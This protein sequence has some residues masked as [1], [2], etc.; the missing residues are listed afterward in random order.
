MFV[1][2]SLSLLPVNATPQVSTATVNGTI[3][4]ESKAV[5]PGVTVTATDLQTGRQYVA[6][7]DDRG[8]YRLV[9]MPPGTYKMQAELP[10]FSTVEMQRVELLVGQNATLGFVMKIAT[11]AETLTV[12]SEAP[13]VDVR[14][15]QVA[16][17]V[18]RRQMDAVPVQGRNWMELSM[19]VKGITTNNATT[20][21]GTHGDAFQL[22]LDGQQIKQNAIGAGSGQ[23]RFSREAIAEFQIVTNLFDVTQGRSTGVQVHAISRSG[24][25]DISGVLYG[26]FRD[27][28]L[29]AAD[30]VANQVLPYSNQQIG[31]VIGGPIVRDK[32]HYFFSYE[33][34][35]QPFTVFTQPAFLGGGSFTQETKTRHHSYLGRVDWQPSPRNSM[36]FR[37]SGFD[38]ESPFQLSGGSYP[39]RAEARENY[40]TNLVA[41]WN[42]VVSDRRVR[43]L[44]VGYF[45]LIMSSYPQPGFEAVPDYVFPGAAMGAPY[46]LPWD[47]GVRNSYQFRYDETINRERHNFKFGGEY[48][49]EIHEGLFELEKRGRMYFTSLPS[50][51]EMSRR[52]P[53]DQWNNP[54]AWDL[55][56]LDPIVQRYDI[57]FDPGSDSIDPWWYSVPRPTVALWF[58]D[59][60]QVTDRLTLNYGVRW[61]DDWGA[62]SPPEITESVIPIDN[63]IESG[64]FGYRAGIHDHTN[65]APRAGFVYNFGG[66]NDFVIRGGSGRYFSTPV[67]NLVYSHQLYNRFV[68]ASFANDRQP[69]FVTDPM[70]GITEQDV[71]SGS[72][73]VPAQ[74][75]RILSP[76]LKMPYTWQS[77]IGFQ[78]Q[79]GPLMAI[80]SDLTHW[81]W[82]NQTVARDPNLLFDPVTGYNVDPRFGRPNPAYGQIS[83]YESIGKQDYLALATGF[84]RRLQDNFQAGA[85][86]TLMFYQHDDGGS[87]NNMGD[88]PFDREA[89]W[90]RSTSF[91]RNTVRLWGMYQFP[92]GLS[93]SSVYF[94]GSGNYY[95]GTI[96]GAPYGKPGT[97]R[98][99]IGAPITIPEGMRE[100]F[101]GPDLIGS[102][103]VA[104]RN[105]LRGTP[106]HKVDLRVQQEIRMVG[107]VRLQLVGEVFNLFNSKNYGSFVT[108][109]NNS[110]F[111]EPN[112]NLGNAYVP[113]SGQ[114]G[115]RVSF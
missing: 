102:G 92:I 108:Q 6:V 10:S 2:L 16:G 82:Y 5:L 78:K 109:I 94:Y 12:I 36:S 1:T 63:G 107:N 28:K 61:D 83:W 31:G 79:L 75:K 23:P 87:W 25:N 27:D 21:P 11:L 57:S 60:W 32:L 15:S 9:N 38:T 48:L 68:S 41:T 20:S 44:H 73:A 72:V 67:T 46:N 115:F 113:R 53:I 34:E 45:Q 29:N 104:P 97:N 26:Y 90:A 42:S 13:L 85:T 49:H 59:T 106:L 84:T 51:A 74:T 58:G 96:S 110:R 55:T 70:R 81:I 69:G 17:Y 14:S 88:N 18:D 54:A 112:Q 3:T 35:N 56:G 89:E 76:D 50:P 101:D 30:P 39:T 4:D 8:E 64:D 95:G 7:S 71:L 86:Y 114:L 99:N 52:F 43:V 80:E 103:E 91:Q 19:L 24:T 66:R 100:R 111:G 33:N 22:N 105:A 40:G 37:A 98:L 77:S 65:I 93:V 47:E 62:A